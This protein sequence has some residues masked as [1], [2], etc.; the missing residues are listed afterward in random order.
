VNFEQKEVP[1]RRSWP[2]D[3]RY[4]L[5]NNL[6]FHY[7]YAKAEEFVGEQAKIDQHYFCFKQI[8]HIEAIKLSV[9]KQILK[10]N[11]EI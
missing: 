11:Q 6:N 7:I 4:L 5:S 1:I 8:S 2:Y 3:F 9:S 10:L